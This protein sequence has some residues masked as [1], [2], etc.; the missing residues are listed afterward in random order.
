MIA[1]LASRRDTGARAVHDVL[2]DRLGAASVDWVLP[3]DLVWAGWSHRV[4]GSGAASTR[5]RLRDGRR[6]A[7]D[8][9]LHRLVGVPIGRSA[10][11]AKDRDYISSEFTAL[12]A[13]WLLSLGPRVLGPLGAYVTSLGPSPLAALGAAEEHGLPVA[14]RGVLTRGGLISPSLRGERHVP[15]LE[16]PGAAS[17]PVPVDVVSD[18]PVM[19]RLLVAAG[20]VHGPLAPRYGAAAERLSVALDSS[21]LELSFADGPALVDV[22][23]MPPLDTA[24]HVEAVADALIRLAATKAKS[25]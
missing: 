8:A 20:R 22:S 17:A 3:M 4:A 2:V 1:V 24:S 14:R 11:S 25:A 16:W 21:L 12:I 13:S 18:L 15:R 9:V 5:V 7:P 19:T 6:L 23:A 10:T